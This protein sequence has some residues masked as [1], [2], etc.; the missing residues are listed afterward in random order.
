MDEPTDVTQNGE[1]PRSDAPG[2]R[3]SAPGGTSVAGLP[4]ETG[5]LALSEEMPRGPMSHALA[6]V[7]N[8]LS[9][10]ESLQRILEDN[11]EPTPLMLRELLRCGLATG[12]LG[13]AL[14][15]WLD[16]TRRAGDVRR[17]IL[18]GLAYPAVLIGFVVGLFTTL[19]VWVVPELGRLLAGFNTE[20][21]WLTVLLLELSA[22]LRRYGLW[23]LLGLTA[24]TLALVFW[25]R[26]SGNREF[27]RR[28]LRAIPV[29]GTAIRF[30]TLST[31]CRLLAELVRHRVP[32]PVAVRA[33][34]NGTRDAV[35]EVRCGTLA[36]RMAGGRTMEQAAK[37]L[38]EFPAQL[39]YVFRSAD[40][41]ESF[42]EIL[43]GT[44]E[45]CD[46]QARVRAG[47]VP[48]V[49]EPMVIVSI[50]FTFILLVV[51][52]FWPLYQLIGALT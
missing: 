40:S 4:L 49:A 22:G 52:M 42:V 2:S 15:V 32:L 43:R 20:L 7:S 8:R 47:L 23:L 25:P 35:L 1:T 16:D 48:L 29:I 3:G 26:V 21:P 30:A 45:M 46:A 9:R 38:P 50:A 17:R 51:A 10:G 33:A 6:A 31:F 14:V 28:L 41:P 13:E 24:L 36:E 12:T 37:T 44:A 27:H 11:R 34:G 39:V 19:M 18:G 5:L